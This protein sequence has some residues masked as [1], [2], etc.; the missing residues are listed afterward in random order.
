MLN[1]FAQ[2]NTLVKDG[3]PTVA[4]M[5]W[6]IHHCN[7]W[8][9]N[10]GSTEHMTHRAN[11]FESKTETT[12]ELPVIIPNGD[13]IPV[14]GKG[15]CNLPNRLRIKDVLHVPK[16]TC[17]LLSVSRFARGLRCAVTFFPYFCVMQNLHMNKLIGV[18]KCV[19]GIYQMK[20]IGIERMAM[21]TTVAMWHKRLGHASHNKL[22]HLDFVKNALA[23]GGDKFKEIGRPRVLLGYPS[24]TKGYKVYDVEHDKIVVL[25]DVRFFENIFP[26]DSN[27]SHYK[28]DEL[29]SLNSRHGMEVA[30]TRK[31]LVLSQRKYVM[32][33]LKDSGM[34]GCKPSSFPMEQNSKLKKDDEEVRVDA[35]TYKRL[36]GHGSSRVGLPCVTTRVGHVVSNVVV[37]KLQKPASNPQPPRGGERVGH[38]ES[39]VV[40]GQITKASLKPETSKRR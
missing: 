32:D 33:I 3:V 9:I 5:I 39:D 24:G 10:T 7:D 34:M 38:V 19:K 11:W 35:S 14:K 26:C 15:V 1:I 13:F 2:R 23:A 18:G 8:I 40:V 36:V 28:D 30:R 4:N 22:S 20:I 25:R 6:K 16:F 21:M 27:A 37:G 17:N 31:G 29:K 12:H